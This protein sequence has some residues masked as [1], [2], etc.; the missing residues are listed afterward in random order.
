M[1]HFHIISCEQRSDVLKETLQEL[2]DSI[3]IEPKIFIT[4][5]H[6][7][8]SPAENQC[9]NEMISFAHAR[10]TMQPED[11]LLRLEDDVRPTRKIEPVIAKLIEIP[12]IE[13]FNLGNLQTPFMGVKDINGYQLRQMIVPV[14]GTQAMLLSYSTVQQLARFV[15]GLPM[16]NSFYFPL[17]GRFLQLANPVLFEHKTY[18]SVAYPNRASSFSTIS[19]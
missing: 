6:D 5:R 12:E 4:P 13:I 8:Q 2:K 10:K 17:Q 14:L 3:N 11:W 7:Q 18:P 19:S 1:I 9:V 15:I 16:E